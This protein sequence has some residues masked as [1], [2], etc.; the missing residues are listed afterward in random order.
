MSRDRPRRNRRL[1][2]KLLLTA[3][4]IATGIGFVA[5]FVL[6]YAVWRLDQVQR[7]EVHDVLTAPAQKPITASDLLNLSTT[8]SKD[9]DQNSE[10]KAVEIILASTIGEQPVRG[11]PDAE[12]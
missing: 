4:G 6:G 1:S 5:S 9:A 3:I 12:N 10:D 7:F 2:E 8:S 11:E